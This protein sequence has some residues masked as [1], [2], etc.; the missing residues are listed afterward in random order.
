MLMEA[1][2]PGSDVSA[3]EVAKV[4]PGAKKGDY[5]FLQGNQSRSLEAE[6]TRTARAEAGTDRHR[7]LKDYA[8]DADNLPKTLSAGSK[9]LTEDGDV[10]EA[11]LDDAIPRMLFAASDPEYVD[12]L[13]RE[14]LLEVVM[15]GRELRKVAREASNVIN[16]NTRVGDVPIASDEEFARPTG[17]GAE[18]R[19]DGETYTTVAWNATKL[20][21][22]SRV[23]DEMRDQAMVDLIERNIQRVGASL[24]NG[25]NRVFL[26]E[27]VDNAQNNHDTAGSNQGYQALNSAVGE[28][29]KDD[30]RPDT[31]VTHPDYR[32]QLFNDTNLAYAN[33]A[34]T[35]EVLR[36]REDAPIVGDIAGLDMHAAMSSATYDDGT[37]IGWSGGSETWGF[38]SDGDKGAVVYDRD[39][40]HTILY[41]PNGQDVEIKDYEDP[42]RDITGVN[43]R[44]HVDCQYSQGRSS[45]TV[46]Y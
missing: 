6:M 4:W 33:R 42:I 2:L 30:F 29:D 32:T 10:I 38:S 27:L 41:A 23:T 18:I 46:Q 5:S 40:I 12:T 43:G 11:R 8:V 20:T 26:T 19:D 39:N 14:Q 1:A 9:H 7:A 37:D 16:A 15:E 31:Y 36:N 3:R 45:A 17:Q 24:E 34:G 13:F 28:V 35:N 22:G 21:E 44:L 25:I